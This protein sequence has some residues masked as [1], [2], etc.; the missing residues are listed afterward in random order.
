MRSIPGTGEN[1]AH[2][3]VQ[4]LDDLKAARHHGETPVPGTGPRRRAAIL[5]VPGQRPAPRLLSKERHP[6]K[7]GNAFSRQHL[8]HVPNG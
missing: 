7:R 3:L 2:R 5:A 4:T 1:L 8:D 6:L